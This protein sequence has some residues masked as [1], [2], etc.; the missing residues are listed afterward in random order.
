MGRLMLGLPGTVRRRVLRTS[1]GMGSWP[2]LARAVAP[3][4]VGR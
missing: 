1:L 3:G 4:L 2:T